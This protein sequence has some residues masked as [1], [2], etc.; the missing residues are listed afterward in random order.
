MRAVTFCYDTTA[1]NCHALRTATL[2]RILD[3]IAGRGAY[4]APTQQRG[5]YLLRSALGLVTASSLA[6]LS[7]CA[8]SYS[9]NTY[10]AAAAQQASKVDRGVVIGVREVKISADASLGTVT[11]AAAGGIA[12]ST[13]DDSGPVKALSALGGSVLGGLVGSGVQHAEGDATA[14]EYIVRES[15]ASLVSVTQR[16][17]APLPIGERVLVIAG[18][19]AR[20]VPDYTV[21]LPSPQPSPAAARN[22]RPH[23]PAAAPVAAAGAAT[24]VPHPE[25]ASGG[26]AAQ[27]GVADPSSLSS[28]TAAGGS[29]SNAAAAGA[30]AASS[31]ANAG[32]ETAVFATP[33]NNPDGSAV[34]AAEQ[35]KPV[36]AETVRVPPAAAP[37]APAAAG[38]GTAAAS[39]PAA[40]TAAPDTP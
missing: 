32:A 12:G 24:S 16:D 17:K 38:G 11:G 18:K 20:I 26:I 10:A 40:A 23:P 33:L 22:V 25:S 36:P 3:D 8:P 30:S 31:S 4:C 21:S 27:T 2:H 19:Q 6:I 9:P 14:F 13:V 37:A 35:G 39:T 29:T 28:A 5:I 1:L 34:A 15:D 7:G